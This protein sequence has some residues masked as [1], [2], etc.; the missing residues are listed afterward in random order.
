MDFS[1]VGRTT[2][3]FF[4]YQAWPSVTKDANG[5]LYAA[6]SGHR[7]G[8]V[9]PFGKNLLYISRDD[10]KS[11]E[12]PIIAND[13][14][15][16]D[17]DAGLCAWG[18]GNLV[19]TWFTL[20][21][22][23]FDEREARTPLLKTPLALAARQLWKDLPVEQTAP[24]AFAKLSRDGGKT[25]SEKVRVPVTCPHGPIRRKDGSLLM[26]GKVYFC[27]DESYPDKMICAVESRDDGMT[28]QKLGV[29]DLPEGY[30]EERI[31]EPHVVELPD[32][33]LLGAVRISGGSDGSAHNTVY[34]TVSQDGGKTWSKPNILGVCGTPPHLLLHSSGA[35]VMV[36]SRR[37]NPH[38]QRAI[39]SWDGGRTWSEEIVIAPESP[40]WDHGYPAS[41]ELSDGSILTVYYQKYPGDD[42]N[43][44][45]CSRWE[46]PAKE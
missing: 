14:Y 13:S 45:L 9:C 46:L 40:D 3:G 27:P 22:S 19:L 24:G 25:W 34:T 10:G 26:L 12:G 2:D 29:V 36:Y 35:V 7:L 16:D 20:R 33:S 21:Q 8:H 30:G 4:R 28:W 37:A 38:G 17:R 5:I 6:A 42:Y 44:I 32:G 23:L 31:H 41:V 11:W 18:D 15:M 39:V 43:S 1:V